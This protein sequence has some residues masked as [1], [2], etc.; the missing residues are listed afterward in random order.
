MALS[1]HR[2]RAGDQ[3]VVDVLLVAVA[4]VE[5]GGDA[6]LGPVAGAIEQGALG[7]D[8]NLAGLGQVQ[9]DRQA[10]Q[11]AADD[12]DVKF[13]GMVEMFTEAIL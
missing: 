1:S 9:G 2:P 13:H 10:G 3:G 4:R 7:N 11:A 12:R 6:A 5:H 8:G